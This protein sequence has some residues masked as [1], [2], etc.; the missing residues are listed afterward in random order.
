MTYRTWTAA[1]RRPMATLA[2]AT[3]FGIVLAAPAQARQRQPDRSADVA[4]QS[5]A[6]DTARDVVVIGKTDPVPEPTVPIKERADQSI[7][8]RLAASESQRFARCAKRV[9]PQLVRQAIEG[10]PHRYDSEYA[11][12]RIIR[13]EQSCY[14]GLPT[15]VPM[16]HS[17]F[18]GECNPVLL[19]SG[20]SVCRAFFDR[21]ALIERMI[22]RFAPTLSFRREDL[23]APAVL[24][25]FNA[26]NAARNATR[27]DYERIGYAVVAC[28]VATHPNEAL[29]LLRAE[30]GSKAE[31][32]LRTI[33]LG[34][35]PQCLGGAKR[36]TTDGPQFR[37]YLAETVYF[38]AAALRNVDSLIPDDAARG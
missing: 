2:Q 18:Y 19:G 23:M 28:T 31:Q 33:L 30:P 3:M 8:N 9:D 12:D 24:D 5:K 26:R 22:G 17:P 29:A 32:R 4:G 36:I 35:S 6:H 34:Q 21:G 25:R 14:S 11:L 13:E 37:V 20:I 16:Q 7:N 15:L 38:F 10:L 1:L 27:Y